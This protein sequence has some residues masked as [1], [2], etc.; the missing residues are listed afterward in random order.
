MDE[1]D[2]GSKN[3][4]KEQNNNEL[5]ILNDEQ[6]LKGKKIKKSKD[7]KKQKKREKLKD[8]G[9]HESVRKSKG[10][11]RDKDSK[12]NTD[13]MDGHKRNKKQLKRRRSDDDEERGMCVKWLVT[14]YTV[15]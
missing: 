13:D 3:T 11:K 7:S 5:E 9:V 8:T 6:E 15:L 14:L 12:G 4:K 10:K 2:K 1:V